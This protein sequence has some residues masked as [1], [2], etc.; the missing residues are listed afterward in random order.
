MFQTNAELILASQ[1]PRRIDFFSELG[2]RFTSYPADINETRRENEAPIPF[3][4]RIACEK[5]EHVG[6]RYSAA[7][8]VSAD[9]IVTIDQDVLG[10][11][12]SV[13]EAAE[14]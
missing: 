1:S 13:G 9:T 7:W 8:I 14:M 3:V 12:Q 4:K 11:P 2:L 5:A 6:K 10:K